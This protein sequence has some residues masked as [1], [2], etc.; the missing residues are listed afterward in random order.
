MTVYN[1]D[2]AV[3]GTVVAPDGFGN[4]STVKLALPKGAYYLRFSARSSDGSELPPVNYALTMDVLT[5]PIGPATVNPTAAAT[6][7]TAW[8]GTAP[9]TTTAVVTTPTPTTFSWLTPTDPY[10][11]PFWSPPPAAPAVPWAM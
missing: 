4:A 1:D 3:V 11:N 7:P 9:A 2:G 5:D 6:A 8:G 10:A